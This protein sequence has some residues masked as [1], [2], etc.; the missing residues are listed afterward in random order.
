M[1]VLSPLLISYSLNA[2]KAQSG[3]IIYS[4]GNP[5]SDWQINYRASAFAYA[6]CSVPEDPEEQMPIEAEAWA[7]GSCGVLY[8]V[9]NEASMQG[10]QGDTELTG[11]A[12]HTL[13]WD[14]TFLGSVDGYTDCQGQSDSWEEEG[15]GCPEE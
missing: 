11:Q 10:Y 6:L 7:E 8:P 4:S 5:W 9:L 13:A 12:R 3:E 2:V 1:T 14:G 15:D